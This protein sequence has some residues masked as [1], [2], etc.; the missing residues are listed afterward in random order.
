M[1]KKRLIIIFLVKKSNTSYLK[2]THKFVI[3]VTNYISQA[4]ALDKNNGNTLWADA[5]AKETKDVNP[6]FRKLDNEE[7]VP[8]GYQHVNYHMIFDV[9]MEDLR[10]MAWL[11]AGGHVTDPPAT[12]SYVIVVS[13]ETV[14]MFL[15]L[16]TLNYFPVKVADIQNDYITTPITE[17]IWTVLGPEF[18]KDYGREAIVVRALYGLKS[19]GAKF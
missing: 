2:K 10:F 13:R 11:V 6:A 1:L 14:R 15:T 9:K 4:Y 18:G 17:K 12:I 16:T 3:E 7:I 8:I 19:S 5:I